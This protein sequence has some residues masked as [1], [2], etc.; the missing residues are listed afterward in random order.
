MQ[1]KMKMLMNT[2]HTYNNN[3]VNL[4]AKKLIQNLHFIVDM[5]YFMSNIHDFD[6][7]QISLKFAQR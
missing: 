6:D 4:F 5:A 7:N 1:E 2:W 3:T